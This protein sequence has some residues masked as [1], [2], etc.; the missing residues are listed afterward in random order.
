MTQN[1][2]PATGGPVHF[3]NPHTITSTCGTCGE[4]FTG[5]LCYTCSFIGTIPITDT[6]R[7]N[8]ITITFCELTPEQ[9]IQLI[10][11]DHEAKIAATH[12]QIWGEP[13]E[14]Q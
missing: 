3:R 13:E 10:T 8:T 2:E 1:P 7:W 11:A 9:T 12:K 4:T 14:T 5:I 6:D